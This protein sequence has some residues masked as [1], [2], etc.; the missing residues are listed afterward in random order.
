MKLNCFKQLYFLKTFRI[1]FYKEYIKELQK[2]FTLK[3]W[4]LSFV[5]KGFNENYQR[6]QHGYD[7]TTDRTKN[8]DCQV[9]KGKCLTTN[10]KILFRDSVMT[11]YVKALLLYKPDD[12]SSIS[13]TH[14]R[15]RELPSSCTLTSPHAL[16]P[17]HF[18]TMKTMFLINTLIKI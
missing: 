8:E 6:Q 5:S 13:R 11:Q 15:K 14:C 1:T 7:E 12:P 16:V 4:V 2:E 17:P 3:S 10:L 9:D 18:F